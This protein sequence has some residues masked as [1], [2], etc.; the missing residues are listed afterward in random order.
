MTRVETAEEIGWEREEKGER[1][2]EKK[3]RG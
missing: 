3:G 1:G 2:M